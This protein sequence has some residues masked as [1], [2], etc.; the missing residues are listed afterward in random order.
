MSLFVPANKN[1]VS[2]IFVVDADGGGLHRLDTARHPFKKNPV[3]SPDGKILAFEVMYTDF[4]R[5][6]WAMRY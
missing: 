1:Y 6:I 2:D 4:R 5:E 3:F